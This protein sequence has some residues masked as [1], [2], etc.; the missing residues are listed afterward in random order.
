MDN[1]V[2]EK[3]ETYVNR[4]NKTIGETNSDPIDT[5]TLAGLKKS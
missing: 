1:Q 2:F 4:I 3:L 5:Y